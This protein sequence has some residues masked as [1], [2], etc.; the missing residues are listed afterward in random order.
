MTLFAKHIT[1][2]N[3]TTVV[4]GV[5]GAAALEGSFVFMKFCL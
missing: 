4:V 1:Q 3:D 2:C 5:G